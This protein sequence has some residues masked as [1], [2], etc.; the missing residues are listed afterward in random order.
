MPRYNYECQVCNNINLYIHP[1]AN[2]PD[3]CVTCETTGS[4]VRDYSKSAF[5]VPD[6]V[7]P[8]NKQK[9]GT[10]TKEYIEQNREILNKQKKDLKNEEYE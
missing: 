2:K 5:M 8:D 7:S 9:P 4:L 10:L 6:A 1:I 3:T